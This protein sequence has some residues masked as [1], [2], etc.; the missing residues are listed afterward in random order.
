MSQSWTIQHEADNNIIYVVFHGTAS[1]KDVDPVAQSLESEEHLTEHRLLSFVECAG[2][3]PTTTELL[4]IARRSANWE[5]EDLK[6]AWLAGTQVDAGLLRIIASKFS[7][8]VMRVFTSEAEARRWL[9][10]TKEVVQDSPAKVDHQPIRL[11]GAINLEQVRQTQLSLHNSQDFDPTRPLLWDLREAQLSESL[12][13]VKDL[14][15]PI[16]EN[17]NQARAGRK[18]AVLVDS[19]IM[20]LLIREMAKVDAWPVEDVQV[21][22]SYRDA[23][24][25]LGKR[26]K[27]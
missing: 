21:F 4:E 3:N 7:D 16:A 6:I 22:R 19:H 1:L 18:S 5:L 13:E 23:I 12:A 2:L 15:V 27:R 25:W 24:A 26:R 9:M 17:H 14:A 8:K 11:R 20:D 10:G